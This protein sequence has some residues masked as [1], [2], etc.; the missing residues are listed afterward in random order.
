MDEHLLT[1][2]KYPKYVI[3]VTGSS[4]KGSTTSL[5]A[6]ILTESGLSVVWNSS[7]SNIVN[8]TATLIKC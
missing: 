5:I 1:K 6:H 7:G 2:I 3:G 8:G 4:G